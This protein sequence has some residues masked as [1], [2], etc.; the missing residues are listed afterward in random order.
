M[1]NV[2]AETESMTYLPSQYSLLTQ[3]DPS[4][5]VTYISQLHHCD[6]HDYYNDYDK[7]KFCMKLNLALLQ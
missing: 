3:R 7:D 6:S 5:Q 4:H 1:A 2:L